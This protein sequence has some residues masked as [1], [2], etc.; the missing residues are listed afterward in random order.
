MTT[1]NMQRQISPALLVACCVAL[2]LLFA[3]EPLA[4]AQEDS[5]QQSGL[6]QR[7]PWTTSRVVGSPEPP[8]PYQVEP[9]Y[10]NIDWDRPLYAKAEPD[11]NNLLVVEQGGEAERPSR[12]IRIQDDPATDSTETFLEYPDRL[13]YGLEFHPDYGRNRHVFIFSNGPT[14]QSERKNRISRFTVAADEPRACDPASEKIILE[15]RSMGH[16]GGD[17]VF[18]HDRML[19]ITSGDGTSDSD[20]WL[21]A[22]DVSN[23]LGGVL[24]IDVDHA[25]DGRAYSIPADN[26]FLDVPNARGELWAFGLRNPW[27]M[28]VDQRTGHIWVGNNGQDLWETAHLVRRGD[29]YGW[30]VYEGNHPFYLNRQLGPAPFVPPTIEHHHTEARSLTGGVVYYGD[31]FDDL[32]GAYVYGDYSTGKIWAARHDGAKLTSHLEIAD[33]ALQIAG[34]AQSPRGDLLVVDHGGGIYR[35]VPNTSTFDPEQFPNRLSETGLF[36]SVAQNRVQPGVLSYSVNSPAWNDGAHVARFLALPGD[37]Q[38]DYT[39]SRGWNFPDGTVLMQTLSI[40]DPASGNDSRRRIE[41][42]LLTRQQGEWAGYSYRWNDAQDDAVL[43]ASEGAEAVLQNDSQAGDHAAAVKW[44]FPSRA[45]CLSCHSRAVNFVLGMTELQMN[46]AHDDGQ[47]VANQL[48]TFDHIG[49]LRGDLPKPA[50]EL[51]RLVDPYDPSLDVDARARSYLHANCSGC[52]VEAGGGNARMELEFTRSLEAMN[53]ADAHPQHDTFGIDQVRIVAP[54][55]PER[56]VL[57]ARVSRRGRGQMPPLVSQRVDAQGVELLRAW[58]A[59]MSPQRS[60]VK[61]WQVDDLLPLLAQVREERSPDAGSAVF[62]EAGCSQCH[63]FDGEGGGAGP[64]LTGIAK[65]L[66]P[67]ELVE[68]IVA[69]SRSIAEDYASSVLLLADG[70]LLEGRI[71]SETDDQLILRVGESFAE[72]VTIAKS[73]IEARRLSDKSLMPSG[74]LNTFQQE[75]VLDLLAYL[76]ADGDTGATASG[77]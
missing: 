57:L 45:E 40:K 12:V 36:A 20:G 46:R 17:L 74:A 4:H 41:T 56:S 35:L 22:Q 26:P 34:F 37:E 18:G 19:Y 38:I 1:T 23:L 65:R 10:E 6:E 47:V 62:R 9:V 24:R 15:W 33:S 8:P 55:D 27:R 50:A 61:D 67:H 42:R 59:G 60:F 77:K 75:Q 7:V 52:H 48:H 14:G 76:M 32:S 73:Q 5:Q 58:I 51:S 70:R 2:S 64:D 53:V 44:R 68:S 72:P 49:M 13:I 43:V 66:K 54:G 28:T 21:S 16:D 29:N 69:P 11:T 30:S 25:A 63:R 3:G 71:E 31:R 39:S